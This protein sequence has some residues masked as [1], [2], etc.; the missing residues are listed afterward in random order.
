[1]IESV[2][3]DGECVV[4]RTHK[5][6]LVIRCIITWALMVLTLKQ[7]H[8]IAHAHLKSLEQLVT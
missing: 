3:D 2:V 8:C 5:F 1:M 6:A 7:M 4:K